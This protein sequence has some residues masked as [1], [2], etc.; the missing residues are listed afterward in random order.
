M[1]P[2]LAA[3]HGHAGRRARAPVPGP[4]LTHEPGVPPH[5]EV[6]RIYQAFS[7]A[8]EAL[9]AWRLD[10]L[11][12]H[13]ALYI[14]PDNRARRGASAITEWFGAMFRRASELGLG[15]HVHF[16]VDQRGIERGV[17]Y[18][19][20]HYLLSVLRPDGTIRRRVGRFVVV[21]RL[22][23]DRRWRCHLDSSGSLLRI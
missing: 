16:V 10:D 2:S 13:D 14:T 7:E 1:S 6:D 19:G 12:S 5:A 4:A 20:G 23:S 8:H 3:K 17:V 15:L 11:Y 9:D 22:G 18:D 21:F